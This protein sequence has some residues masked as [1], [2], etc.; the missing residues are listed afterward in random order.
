MLSISTHGQA[1]VIL[2]SKGDTLV[3]ITPSQLKN[4][5]LEHVLFLQTTEINDS[6]MV[7]CDKYSIKM[8]ITDELIKGFS[9]ERE[10]YQQRIHDADS[11]HAILVTNN[12]LL[13]KQNKSLKLQ[14]NLLILAAVIFAIL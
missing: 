6:L 2:D 5:N 3:C 12:E 1:M 9:Y 13:E 14:R 10:L 8:A 7:L 11:V 4:V